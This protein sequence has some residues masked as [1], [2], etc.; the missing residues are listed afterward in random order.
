M[1]G[2]AGVTTVTLTVA[3]LLRPLGLAAAAVLLGGCSIHS[4]AVNKVGDA[5][6]GSSSNFASDD[7]PELIGQAVPFGLKT[8]EGLLLESPRH[9]GLLFSTT[10]GFV[11]Y[12]YGY[13]QLEADYVEAADLARAT[14][15]RERARRLYFRARAYGLRGLEAA[16][17]GVTAALSKDPV[18]ALAK[19]RK[20]Q[21]PLLYWTAVAWAGA[22]ALKVNDAEV[23][24]DQAIVDALARRALALDE[25]YDLGSIHD[26]FISWEAGRSSI[27]GSMEK[28][29][30][31]YQR[32]LVL[33]GGK[34]AWPYVNYAE[35]VSVKTQNKAEFAEV[36]GKALEVDV[37][38]P[39]DQRLANLLAQKRARWLLGRKDE[40]FVE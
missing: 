29:R 16:S 25:G 11:Q 22:M 32:A 9:K 40:L 14:A 4:M 3:R 20:P 26:F 23:S 12:A 10:S 39:S 33:A 15:Q 13:V 19:T 18:A 6:A 21:A 34:R 35:S 27:G 30:E 8:M 7:D 36:L 28:A 31:H 1:V 38:A 2:F 17:P 24:A 37:T 5:L